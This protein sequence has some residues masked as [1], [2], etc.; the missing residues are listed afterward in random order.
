LSD[1]GNLQCPED[2]VN[3]YPKSKVKVPGADTLRLLDEAEEQA[4]KSGCA[5]CVRPPNTGKYAPGYDPANSPA[6]L[7]KAGHGCVEVCGTLRSRLP[8]LRRTFA[9]TRVATT[10]EVRL[11]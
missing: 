2:F 6:M 1:N 4:V 7:C 8:E 11:Y 3:G 9:S 10:V 5:E